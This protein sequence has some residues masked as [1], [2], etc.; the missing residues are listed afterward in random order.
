M[1]VN[2]FLP[3]CLTLLISTIYNVSLAQ[4][5]YET[6]YTLVNINGKNF[7]EKRTETEDG[8]SYN[9][10]IS[11][12]PARFR[13]FHVPPRDARLLRNLARQDSAYSFI[14]NGFTLD[15]HKVVGLD[16]QTPDKIS[17]FSYGFV[18]GGAYQPIPKVPLLFGVNMGASLYASGTKETSIS[19]SLTE[20][21][22]PVGK[23][24]IP[25]FVQSEG[26]L[27]G[28][29]LTA[30]LIAP[31]KFAQPYI[32]GMAGFQN[33][34]SGI[35]LYNYDNRPIAVFGGDEGLIYNQG[36]SSASTYSLAIGG[37][38]LINLSEH[39]NLDL[40]ALYS[41]TGR[42]RYYS[43]QNISDWQFAFD[44]AKAALLQNVYSKNDISPSGNTAPKRASLEMLMVS[45]GLNVLFR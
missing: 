14:Y 16:V 25:V 34:S 19:F 42:V 33:I 32:L 30:Q 13:N 38:L 6:T 29:H 24:A 39:Y 17:P 31:I 35:K 9:I 28:M 44:G 5:H 12:V 21:G 4:I 10:S 23:Y 40:R 18:I 37:G 36:I 3:I 8:G 27:F 43:A 7:Y 1:R 26:Y 15:W 41:G 45:I 11:A 20:Q 2:N 22:Q